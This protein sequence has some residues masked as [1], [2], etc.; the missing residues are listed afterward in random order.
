MARSSFRGKKACRTCARS[1]PTGGDGITTKIIYDRSTT[2]ESDKRRR[3][4]SNV[5]KGFAL[6]SAPIGPMKVIRGVER[7]MGFIPSVRSLLPTR[8]NAPTAQSVFLIASCTF[9]IL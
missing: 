4:L 5:G 6:V 7:C 8:P 3:E 2:N 1:L 9:R